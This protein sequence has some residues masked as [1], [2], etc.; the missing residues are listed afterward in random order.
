VL[1]GQSWE[2]AEALIWSFGSAPLGDWLD[3]LGKDGA[4][5]HESRALQGHMV[6]H[7]VTVATRTA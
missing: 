3:A 1:L 6:M 7:V 2:P 5:T 4:A